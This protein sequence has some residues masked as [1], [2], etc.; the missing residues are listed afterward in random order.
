MRIR[1][2]SSILFTI[3]FSTLITELKASNDSTAVNKKRLHVVYGSQA[4]T[5]TV[6]IIGMNELWYKNSPQRSFHW[7]N[8]NNQWLQVDKIGH[9]YS[10]FQLTRI[11][12]GAFKWAGLSTKN[13][14][15]QATTISWLMISSIELLDGFAAD[16]G[17]SSGDLIAN[18]IGAGMA[19]SQYL[20]WGEIKIQFKYSFHPTSYANER[21]ELL[22][23]NT[24]QEAFKDYNGQTY[25]LSSN[26]SSLTNSKKIPPYLNLA[27]GY[28]AEGMISADKN[29]NESLGYKPYR[30][31]FLSLDL[32]FE[33]LKGK[34]KGIN[35]ILYLLNA[36]K[37]PF[38][39]IEYSKNNITFHP[40]YF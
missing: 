30:K 35:T 10:T 36:I 24:I 17:A 26:I 7:F 23:E 6:G 15:I 29:V 19:L 28:G 34:H 14:A 16:Y 8:D 2:N 31:Y 4:T 20:V 21:K 22:G 37:L 40:I 3:L 18:T 27:L 25:W 5:Y 38:P 9:G 32:D 12:Y 11:N 1:L 33:K 39:T 13:A